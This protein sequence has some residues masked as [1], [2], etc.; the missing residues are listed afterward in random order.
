MDEAERDPRRRPNRTPEDVDR[1]ATVQGQPV[2]YVTS[3]GPLRGRLLEVRPGRQVIGR[4]A[5][6]DL[7]LADPY[8][9]RVHALLTNAHGAVRVEDAGSG[10]GTSLN[11]EPL[12]GTVVLRSGDVLRFG[13]VEV[14]F[15]DG[16]GTPPPVAP[17]AVAP[18]EATI[19][20]PALADRAAHGPDRREPSSVPAS[21]EPLSWRSLALA[22]LA[23][24]I[25]AAFVSKLNVGVV[26]VWLTAAVAPLIPLFVTTSGPRQPARVVAAAWLAL[27]ITFTGFTLPEG[28]RGHALFAKRD[29]TFLPEKGGVEAHPGHALPGPGRW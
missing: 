26:G 19:D 25:S 21:A 10:N 9:S 28:L 23:A 15:D 18:P 3:E 7:C 20:N 5:K 2:L 4:E 17:G 8:V 22:S 6:A 14:V 29:F 24:V 11:G 1:D 12:V 16:R 13:W 27:V